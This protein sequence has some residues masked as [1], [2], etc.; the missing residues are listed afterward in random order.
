MCKLPNLQN[1]ES[2]KYR[3]CFFITQFVFVQNSNEKEDKEVMG[4]TTNTITTPSLT[5]ISAWLVSQDQ[6]AAPE[7]PIIRKSVIT[8]QL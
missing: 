2:A 8:T 1:T 3:I 6:V 4:N 5:K 7:K